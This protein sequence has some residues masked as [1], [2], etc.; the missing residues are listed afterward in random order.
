MPSGH[1]ADMIERLRPGAAAPGEIV[2][3][4]GR[5]LGRH[6]GIIHSP[7]ASGAGSASRPARRS[8]SC[9][10]MPAPAASWSARARRCER[11][12]FDLR[13]INWLGD[14][15]IEEAL[16]RHPEVYVK[17]RSTPAAAAR[18]AAPRGASGGVEVE[19]IAGEDGVSPGQACAF[20]DAAEGQARVLGG[21][22]IADTVGAASVKPLSAPDLVAAH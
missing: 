7:S 2:D 10:S 16:E 11:A 1:Y 17:V 12:A 20:Y 14:G 6:D 18:V 21:G 22:I 4:D 5:V 13:E 15:T 3:L 19:L 8:T 9:G